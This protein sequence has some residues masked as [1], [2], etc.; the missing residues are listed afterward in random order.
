MKRPL[1]PVSQTEAERK[2]E[3]RFTR[4]MVLLTMAGGILGMGV[5]AATHLMGRPPPP[6]PAGVPPAPQPQQ[7][8]PPAIPG[9]APPR[10]RGK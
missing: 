10:L 5:S 2:R 7:T 9:V 8:E 3:R 6:T 4:R 1:K